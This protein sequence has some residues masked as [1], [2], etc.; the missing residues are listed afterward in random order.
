MGISFSSVSLCSSC[1]SF[2]ISSG[3]VSISV[4]DSGCFSGA[5]SVRLPA[6]SDVPFPALNPSPPSG[7]VVSGMKTGLS[8]G[9]ISS[10]M[11]TGL[12]SGVVSS[13]MKTGL[14]SGVVSSGAE[15]GLSSGVVSSGTETELSSGVVSSGM[16]TGLSS[17]VI[18]SG[19]ETGLSSDPSERDS[20]SSPLAIFSAASN[21][22][23]ISSGVRE[24]PAFS[25]LAGFRLASGARKDPSSSRGSSGAAD[26]LFMFFNKLSR[27]S[28]FIFMRIS[29]LRLATC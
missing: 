4:A 16:E 7:P 2:S 19:M 22:A 17:G 15:T 25:S 10:G 27:Y 12:S 8:S 6:L 23:A 21:S 1:N 20:G 13:G 24:P 29:P 14:S 5:S 3:R 11:K 9:V 26:A 28:S 18:S